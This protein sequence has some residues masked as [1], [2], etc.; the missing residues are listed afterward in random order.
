M[1]QKYAVIGMT[2]SACES[3]VARKVGGI[4]G[5]KKVNVN[6]L[7]NTM[8][9][10]FDDKKI[11]KDIVIQ[12][13]KQIGYDAKLLNSNDNSEVTSNNKEISIKTRLTFSLI[14][15]IPLLYL[16]MGSMFEWPLPALL[17]MMD[18]PMTFALTQF[19]LLLPIIY[20]NQSYF[21]RGI[22]G[23]IKNAPNMDSLLAIGSIAAIAYSLFAMFM[24]A[25]GYEI[26]NH[27]IYHKY[28]ME[29]YFE[30]PA[31]ILTLVTVGKY[32]EK[33]AKDK[34]TG[35]IKKL[36]ALLPKEVIKLI[37]GVETL[38]SIKDVFVGD[39]LVAK[40]GEAFAVDG[41]V[42]EGTSSVDQ[43]LINGESTP[44]LVEPNSKIIAGALNV[45]G[46]IKYKALK[47]GEDTT[48]L[49]IVALVEEAA[50]SKA[51]ISKLADQISAIFVPIVMVISLLTFIV[52]TLLG[53]EISLALE[54]AIA[55]L[56][57]SCPC[58]LGL[59]TPVALM[60][61]TGMSAENGAIIKSA[62]ALEN[63]HKVN[64]VVFDKTGTITEGKLKVV[65]VDYFKFSKEKI[66]EI[67]SAIESGFTHPIALAI[68]QAFE[69]KNSIKIDEYKNHPGLGV[70]AKAGN[71]NY[72]LGNL[73]FIKSNNV[74]LTKN[75]QAIDAAINSNSTLVFIVLNQ[76]LIGIISLLD[77]IKES[78]KAAINK[79]KNLGL[80]VIM[81]TGDN[82]QTANMIKAEAGID[83]VYAELLPENKDDIIKKL[84]SENNIVAMVG[85]GINDAPSL[86]RSDVGI[87]IGAGTDIAIESSDIILASNNL[88][89]VYSVI[90]LSKETIKNIKQNLFWAFIYNLVGIPLAAGLFYLSLEW[91]LNPIYASFA[92]SVSSIS[93]VLNA[94]R[95][96]FF[97]IKGEI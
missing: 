90:K 92:M 29:L 54:F 19:L 27:E 6:L 94:S 80:K 67:A 8:T 38:T 77:T 25:Y 65:K 14:F 89:D 36:L 5:V 56:V 16:A 84:Q 13:V 63:A 45:D 49:K 57:I 46:L 70:S 40:P 91:K 86:M 51:P 12:N 93:V 58:A 44:I 26:M 79:I 33:N 59:A 87:A 15:A 3:N 47:I 60:V 71:D 50:S 74:D 72:L 39:V 28:V 53:Y 17:M 75:K 62:E 20:F 83:E 41:I 2:C 76:E 18:H 55:V 73:K 9:V 31:A 43:S 78:S 96:K 88:N 61:A 95:L 69:G 7:T 35:S 30:V 64:V 34:T 1:K 32:I 85:D 24:I 4:D 66:L 11:D 22:K 48:L 21:Y 23:L 82:L 10:D 52:W 37:D 81:L 42:T 97:K 68:N